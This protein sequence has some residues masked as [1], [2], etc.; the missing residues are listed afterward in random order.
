MSN[1]IQIKHGSGIP[2]GKLW[3]FEL[4]FDENNQKLYIG[5]AMNGS[6]LGKAIPITPTL[7]DLGLTASTTELN[8]C[9]GVTSSIQT[10]LN[11]KQSTIK[12]AAST[13]VSSNLDTNRALISD[14]NGKIAVSAVTSTEL[15]Y[16]DGVT[17]AIQTQ[18]NNKQSNITGAATTIVSSNL[19]ADKILISNGNGKIA[20]SGIAS[21]QLGYLDGVTSA[22]QTQ[23]NNKAP[24]THDHDASKIT[25]GTLS[26]EILPVISVEKGGTGA[27]NTT[28]AKINLEITPIFLGTIK[29]VTTNPITWTDTRKCK[30][31]V[32]YIYHIGYQLWGSIVIARSQ[33]ETKYDLRLGGY[34][35]VFSFQ[36]SDD[37]IIMKP[38][39]NDSPS[40]NETYSLWGII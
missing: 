35:W 37:E 39:L 27:N 7:T 6:S 8:Y 36:F 26:S 21:K 4:G 29:N 31:Y 3:P 16:L 33:E 23:L 15:G 11:G 32:L 30:L 2:N 19:D 14:G 13:V 5:G 24:S 22:I 1:L 18:L 20:V 9:D 40:N 10:Q 12:G 17:S 38:G 34:D 25:S 28:D